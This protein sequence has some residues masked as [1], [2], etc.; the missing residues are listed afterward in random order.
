MY[1]G[2]L[3]PIIAGALTAIILPS[4]GIA[5]R[6]VSI[7]VGVLIGMIIWGVLYARSHR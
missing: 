7:A 4:I 6:L 5:N 3:A 1:I 2:D